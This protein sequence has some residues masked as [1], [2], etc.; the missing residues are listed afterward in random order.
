MNKYFDIFK[1]NNKNIIGDV[2]LDIKRFLLGKRGTLQ[3][4]KN[5]LVKDY[6]TDSKFENLVSNYSFY[7]VLKD[8]YD[9]ELSFMF[10]GDKKNDYDIILNYSLSS[11]TYG[12]L[13]IFI[14]LKSV[15]LIDKNK[16]LFFSFDNKYN[17][18][19]LMFQGEDRSHKDYI[20]V[21]DENCG[22]IFNNDGTFHAYDDSYYEPAL[23][24][25]KINK[26][27]FFTTAL[28]LSKHHPETLLKY[29][30]ENE[31]LSKEDIDLTQLATDLDIS[32]NYYSLSI[33]NIVI[34]N[35]FLIE[36]NLISKIK[37]IFKIK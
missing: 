32:D 11:N 19:C 22:I 9:S 20:P 36:N 30:Y 7:G 25:E 34:S 37:N 29:I 35:Q 33:N 6:K 15:I 17:K 27:P 1:N 24:P 23:I 21:S 10:R 8:N 2:E 5:R 4:H 28:G 13:K 16:D 18:V 12:S 3:E 31:K 14:N 26:I